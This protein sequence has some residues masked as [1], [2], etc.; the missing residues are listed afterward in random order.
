MMASES[1]QDVIFEQRER[2]GWIILNRP[3]TL[4]A[5]HP[6]LIAQIRSLLDSLREDTDIGS[7]VI[8]GAGRG[9]SSG[10]DLNWLQGIPPERIDAR[11]F[12]EPFHSL[13]RMLQNYPK[14]LIAAVNGVAAGGGMSLALLCDIAI[15]SKSASFTAS[16]VRIGLV[17]DLGLAYT[18]PRLVGEARAREL[19]LT[20]R[21]VRADEALALGLV[22]R[23]VPDEELPAT[24][25]QIA[26]AIAGNS[27]FALDRIRALATLAGSTDFDNF[28][29]VEASMQGECLTSE[30]HK[31][32]LAEFM[33]RPSERRQ[34]RSEQ[35]SHEKV[36]RS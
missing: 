1:H 8:T 18:L 13:A 15:A 32:R 24:V 23:I 34:G 4:N 14:S 30:E 28:L 12:M 9:F 5:L 29:R 19:M 2:V 11:G 16:F 21:I 31:R 22:S 20:G 3:E 35:I 6:T 10:A 26:G 17:P 33:K 27:A 36:E 25:Q 7:L